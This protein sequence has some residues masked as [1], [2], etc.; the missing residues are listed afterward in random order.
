MITGKMKGLN[1][2][3]NHFL[4]EIFLN[5]LSFFFNL[6]WFELFKKLIFLN[7]SKTDFFYYLM[8]KKAIFYFNY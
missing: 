6:F 1:M 3:A 8:G 4:D 5:L 2:R 7:F